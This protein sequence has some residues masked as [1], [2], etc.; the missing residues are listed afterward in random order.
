MDTAIQTILDAPLLSIMLSS[1]KGGHQ[2]TTPLGSVRS[3]FFLFEN[4]GHLSVSSRLRSYRQMLY[5]L[6]QYSL[7]GPC[8]RSHLF[9][10]TMDIHFRGKTGQKPLY[11]SASPWILW[12]IQPG[13]ATARLTLDPLGRQGVHLGDVCGA[14]HCCRNHTNPAAGWGESGALPGVWRSLL[15]HQKGQE[16]IYCALATGWHCFI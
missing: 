7:P 8:A 10:I 9:P 5:T 6:S 2:G 3:T 13:C 4:S 11:H 12:S 1:I 15:H 16:G 14:C